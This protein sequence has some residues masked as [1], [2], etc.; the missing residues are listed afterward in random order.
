MYMQM[1]NSSSNAD[2]VGLAVNELVPFP[3]P[4]LRLELE[5]RQL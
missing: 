4:D 3:V 2:S 5:V 1:A